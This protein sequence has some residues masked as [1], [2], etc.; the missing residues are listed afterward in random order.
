MKMQQWVCKDS[1]GKKFQEGLPTIKCFSFSLLFKL[2]TEELR[3][4]MYDVF[5]PKKRILLG[6]LFLSSETVHRLNINVQL[7]YPPS[8]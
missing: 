6:V 4:M 5:L 2:F 1:F 8:L 7:Q 3:G